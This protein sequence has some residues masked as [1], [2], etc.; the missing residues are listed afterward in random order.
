MWALSDCLVLKKFT[1]YIIDTDIN[2]HLKINPA[3]S[4]KHLNLSDNSFSITS[5]F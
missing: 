4:L 2:L 5:Q 1:G 3:I